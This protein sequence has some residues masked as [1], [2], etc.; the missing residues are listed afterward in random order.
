MSSFFHEGSMKP[1]VLYYHLEMRNLATASLLI[2]S[3]VWG[4]GRADGLYAEIRT[5][6]G[7]I[8]ARLE[9]ELTPLAVANFVGL[10]EGTVANAAFDAGHPFYD[11]SVYHRVVPGHVIQ[12]GIPKSDRARGPGYTFPNEIHARLSHNHA[13]AL[14]M[15]NS[16]PNTNGAQFCITLGDRG[17]LDGNYTVFGEV[18][19]GMDVVMRIVQGDLVESVR[20]V[21][22]GAKAE[23]FRPTTESFRAMLAEAQKRGEEHAEKKR[24][25]EREW[26]AKNYPGVETAKAGAPGAGSGSALRVKYRGQQVRYVGDV[27][28]REGPALEVTPFASG[29][30]GRPSDALEP[31]AFRVTKV[32]PG[33]DGVVARMKTGERR[34][35]VVPPELG[36]GRA[37]FYGPDTPGKRR[38]V[39]SPGVLLVYDVEALG[40]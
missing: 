15:A 16:G 23:A 14:N 8:V 18:V 21:R 30:D 27:V 20:I 19:A 33:L 1:D 2:A 25:A 40:N 6:K 32:N 29:P 28:G 39:I 38:F 26:V 13:G 36:Y 17:Y 10:A 3:A 5:S 7:M 11:G 34:V 37:G 9:P 4:Q 22:V 24:V 31:E 35:V 12:V